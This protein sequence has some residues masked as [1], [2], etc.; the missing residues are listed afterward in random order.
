VAAGSPEQSSS[1]EKLRT[2]ILHH[3]TPI[4]PSRAMAKPVPQNSIIVN[5]RQGRTFSMTSRNEAAA[6]MGIVLTD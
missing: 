2:E 3:R 6:V 1:R 4:H 5:F